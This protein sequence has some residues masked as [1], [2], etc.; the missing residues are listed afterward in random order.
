MPLSPAR[1]TNIPTCIPAWRAPPARKASK[2]SPTGSRP[3]P[4]P[5]S[6]MPA[7]SRRRST[8]SKHD[9]RPL[10]RSPLPAGRGD[11]QS[12]RV[13]CLERVERLLEAAGMRLLG[14]GEGLEPV[15]DLFEA[16]LA[17]GARH[18]GIHV[19]IFVGLAGD[20]GI[21][22]V[23]GR[24]DRLAGRRVADVLEI[25]EMAVGMAG[26]AFCGRAEHGGNVIEAFDIGLLREIE[27][28][29]IGL[30]FAGKSLFQILFGLGSLERWHV[31]LLG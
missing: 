22:I 25:F 18:A 31:P 30:A 28:A 5:R 14:L 27:I 10:W 21:Q 15:G 24:A 19:G 7:A 3:S 4:R 20:S 1:P 9:T 13:S 11:R 16:F 8:R 17:G 23:V 29:A 2:R 26:L 12:G 6:L